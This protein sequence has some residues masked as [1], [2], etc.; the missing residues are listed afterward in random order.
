M[1]EKE[2]YE[3]GHKYPYYSCEILCSMNGF[4]IEKLLKINKEENNS[5][6]ND[7][8]KEEDDDEDED[9]EENNKKDNEM[10]NDND[11][12]KNNTNSKNN[13]NDN[14][15]ENNKNCE[16][17]EDNNNNIDEKD[18]NEGEH[19]SNEK[20]EKDKNDLEKKDSTNI[21][22]AQ[23]A[24]E[25]FFSF[26]QEKTSID[27]YVLMGYFN[28]ITNYLIKIHTRFILDY[29]LVDN[30][31]IIDQLIS[32]INRYSI[33]NIITNILIAL[34]ENNTPKANEQYM[35]IVNKL[36]DQFNINERDN[37][38][39]EI[40]CELFIESI[41]YNNK[42]KLSKVIDA[43]IITK[44]EIIIK[45]YFENSAENKNKIISVV[46]LLTKLDKSI[47]SN[48]SNKITSVKN[49]DDNKNEML[50]L[51]KY[52]D[53]STNQFYSVNNTRFDFKELVNKSFLSNYSIY[54][55]CISNICI[56]IINYVIQLNQ[57][58]ICEEIEISYSSK[59]A[60]KLGNN[61][62]IIFDFITSV[63]DIY[64]NLLGVIA[65]DEQKKLPII[66]KIKLI[67]NTNIFKIMIEYY[68]TYKNN[69]F[70]INIMLDLIKIIF[71]NDKAPEELIL[72]IL[73]L[74]NENDINKDNNLITL[75]MNDLIKNTKFIYE[76]SNNITNSLLFA[77]NVNILKNIFT[78]NN[79]YMK[80]IYEKMEKET[81]FFKNFVTNIDK[82]FSQKLFRLD[83][84]SDEDKPA[85]VF[86]PIGTKFGV[87]QGK[88]DIE[89]SLESLNEI[90]D[91]YLK[92][93]EKYVKGEDYMPLFKE[94]EDKLEEIK[95]SNEYIR[96][97]NQDLDEEESE[98][99]EDYDEEDIPKPVFFNS[100]LKNKEENED[101]NTN[102]INEKD[103][104]FN[105]IK[106]DENDIVDKQ[107][108]DVNYWHTN[109]KDGD[110][111]EI[112]KELL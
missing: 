103:N 111:E 31:N 107:Y 2:E 74:N 29:I 97:G 21:N 93:Y 16:K 6:D 27:N 54:C 47:L 11:E 72:N 70:Y 57:D 44:F 7:I 89:F 19:E 20:K 85:N 95:K 64:I 106:N 60:R 82:I 34:S 108:N 109:I 17:N 52:A 51:I 104:N 68:F 46:S 32:H 8:E 99:E 112:L 39:I 45:K 101:N 30:Q 9:G 28:K 40:I 36:L 87:G 65:N 26:L 79:P 77:S 38:T 66:E 12:K 86:D 61:K 81:F 92:V 100:K 69:N 35:M 71:E 53:K 49:T 80:K 24:L 83:S 4:N 91:F 3:K 50:N 102:N 5:N 59:K 41:I 110:M 10:E 14:N 88:S 18:A 84:E 22:L 94:R 25:H 90:I 37:N 75:L 33:A 58:N 15:F 1:P 73:Q 96:L 105:K 76:N 62:I 43:N 42:I 55:D 13:I 78:S 67:L 98:E 63:I 23:S 56:I 48:F